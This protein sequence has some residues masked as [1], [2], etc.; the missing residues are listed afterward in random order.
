MKITIYHTESSVD[1]A[2]TVP[3]DMIDATLS[4]LE[5]EYEV[6][7]LDM[8]PGAEVNFRREDNTYSHEITDIDG[9]CYDDAMRWV[10]EILEG[11]YETGAFW[12]N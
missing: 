8:Y 2:A 11:V 10:Q 7:I 5:R 9:D 12:W 4:S 1:P 3:A 6:A